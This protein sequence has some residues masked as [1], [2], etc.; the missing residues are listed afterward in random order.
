MEISVFKG[1][2][3]KTLSAPYLCYVYKNLK[4]LEFTNERCRI[5]KNN[6]LNFAIRYTSGKES[7]CKEKFKLVSWIHGVSKDLRFSY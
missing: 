6:I 5:G 1:L 4:L 3:L 7:H 2:I